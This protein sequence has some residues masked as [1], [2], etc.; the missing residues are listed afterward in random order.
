MSKINNALYEIEKL[1]DTA[2][3]KGWLNEINPTIK[4]FVTILY[5]TL[6]VSFEKYDILKLL[7]MALYPLVIFSL[8]DVSFKDAMHRLRFVLPFV[9]IIGIFNPI[10]DRET[11]TII[12]GIHISAGW[13]SFI[14]LVVKG[15]LTVFATYFLVATTTFEKICYSLRKIH[16]PKIIVTQILLMYRY[17]FV[18]VSEVKKIT[19]AYSLRA[20]NQKG[21]HFKAWGSLVGNLL[22]HTFDRAQNLYDSMCLR[23]YDG[24]FPIQA[25]NKVNYRDILFLII[26]SGCFICFR[27]FPIF[28][29]VGHLIQMIMGKIR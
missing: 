26:L 17:I 29:I 18:F 12:H 3:K 25:Y 24:D 15:F 28:E 13:I 16:I 6:V 8:G 5:I 23:G 4:L 2:K 14:N 10:F 7:A 9:A 11:A 20:P 19:L 21:V 27:I 22:I 1:D